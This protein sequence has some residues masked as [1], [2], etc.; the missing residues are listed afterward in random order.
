MAPKGRPVSLAPIAMPR[1]SLA[2]AI[3][4]KTQTDE[5]K[6]GNAVQKLLHEDPSLRLDR[7]EETHQTLLWGQG[8]THLRI[9]LDRLARK[10]GV[11]VDTEPIEIAYR[12]TITASGSA[13]G[14]HKKQSGGKGQY[15]VC[16]L[17]VAPLEPGRGVEFIDAIVG[18]AIPR[19]F[20]PAVEKGVM[21]TAS[22][23]GALG[24][25][26]V[27]VSVTVFDG[28]F[29]AVDSD[30]MSFRLAS[31]QG[32]RDACT[33][34]GPVLLEPISRVDIVVPIGVQG[35]VLGDLTARR[36]KVQGTEAVGNGEQRIVAFVP[37]AELLRYS[38]DLRSI[39]G[40]RGRFNWAHDHYAAAP[41][42]VTDKA[43][44]ARSAA[45][46]S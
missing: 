31:R 6:L 36:G 14:R 2:L 44:A 10:F 45:A 42:A 43:L 1:P 11:A 15:G 22:Q 46:H 25:P 38:I 32:F 17:R 41:A 30:E 19:Q 5:D 33:A 18:G 21:E 39:S 12:E 24:F 7:N 9:S 3:R 40:G 23:G 8:E 26:V 27:D 20:I 16:S 37:T 28:K 4:A 35:D 13:E 34:A 29:H